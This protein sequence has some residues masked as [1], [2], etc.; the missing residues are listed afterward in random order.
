MIRWLSDKLLPRALGQQLHVR[1]NI[2]S[3]ALKSHTIL[4]YAIFVFYVAIYNI[5]VHLCNDIYEKY[6]SLISQAFLA[7]TRQ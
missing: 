4:S 2:S 3:L 6:S 5:H 7:N 1:V